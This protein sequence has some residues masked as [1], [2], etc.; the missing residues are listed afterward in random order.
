MSGIGT[1]GSRRVARRLVVVVVVALVGIPALVASAASAT[2]SF[3]LSI[4]GWELYTNP[5]PN[6]VTAGAAGG[7]LS[8]CKSLGDRDL[9]VSYTWRDLPAPYTLV[10]ELTT[11]SGR[12]IKKTV[13]YEASAGDSKGSGFFEYP[14]NGVSAAPPG[15]YRFIVKSSGRTA[16]SKAQV[17]AKIC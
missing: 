4:A 7:K 16:R 12:V 14:T 2:A 1:S 17:V 10:T 9:D 8:F 3:K 5:N 6:S 13:R 11:P 15:S